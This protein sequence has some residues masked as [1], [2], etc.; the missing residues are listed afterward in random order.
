M[1]KQI[2]DYINENRAIRKANLE[3]TLKMDKM[4][5]EISSLHEKIARDEE[6]IKALK[7][8]LFK[9]QVQAQKYSN[10]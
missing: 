5:K 2:Q 6:T 4:E 1:A 8:E 9:L 7:Q 10:N 3:L